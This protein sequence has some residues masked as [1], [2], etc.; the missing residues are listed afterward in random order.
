MIRSYL[1]QD[2]VP[3][4]TLDIM[5]KAFENE[6]LALLKNSLISAKLSCL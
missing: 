1:R 4:I 5:R 2:A 6:T 3:K